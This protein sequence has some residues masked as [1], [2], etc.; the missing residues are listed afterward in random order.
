MRNFS[1]IQN[2]ES[3]VYTISFSSRSEDIIKS[4]IH[5]NQLPGASATDDYKS[6]IF[7]AS[8]VKSFDTYKKSV[9]KMRYN[10][11]LSMIR[12]LSEQLDY[13]INSRKKCFLLYTLENLLV[14]DDAKFVYVSND[15]LLSIDPSSETMIFS[16]PLSKTAGFLSPEILS[17]NI[18]PC[19]IHYK[20][21]YYSLGLLVLYGLT[22]VNDNDS[23]DAAINEMNGLGSKIFGFVKRCLDK[24]L[25]SRCLLFI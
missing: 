2:N 15:H 5:T 24:D 23:M 12:G 9:G 11:V 22:G 1:I 19:K 4:I 18:I 21:I 16:F 7:K 6:I 3:S 10:D 8:S 17:T 14:I 13:L 25:N 20:T